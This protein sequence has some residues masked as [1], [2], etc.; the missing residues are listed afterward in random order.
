MARW[1]T[2]L[3]IPVALPLVAREGAPPLSRQ[4]VLQPLDAVQRLVLPPT[5][6]QAELAADA[7][8]AGTTPLRY[9]A[10]SRVAVTPATHG[11]WEQLPDGR[12]WRLR[13]VSAGA[14]DLNFGFTAFRLPEGATLHVCSESAPYF[15]GP[16]TARDNKPHGQLWTPV[17]PGQSACIE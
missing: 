11:T 3:I 14:T 13:I 16:Y 7:R 10:P 9:A 8:A 2:L 15:Q 1:I 12:L 4:R 6:P 17:V 5:D